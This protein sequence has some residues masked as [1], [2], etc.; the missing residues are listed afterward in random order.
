MSKAERAT[1]LS[2]CSTILITTGCSATDGAVERPPNTAPTSAAAPTPTSVACRVTRPTTEGIPTGVRQT[3]DGAVFGQGTLWVGAWWSDKAV[4]EQARQH[5]GIKY[6]SFTI[7]DDVVTDELGPPQVSAKRLDGEGESSGDTGG[8][9]TAEDDS[10]KP[11][12]WWPTGIRFSS[13]GCWQV[14]ETVGSTSITYVVD[15]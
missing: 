7:Q 15:V 4:L 8:Y 1:L 14:T 10:G 12:H 13:P 5:G 2:L 11:L 9:A 6:P 3:H